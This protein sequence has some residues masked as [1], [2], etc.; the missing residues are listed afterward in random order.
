MTCRRFEQAVVFINSAVENHDPDASPIQ[1]EIILQQFTRLAG[2]GRQINVTERAHLTLRR[3]KIE[4]LIFDQRSQRLIEM[5]QIAFTE[6]DVIPRIGVA[7]F[8]RYNLAQQAQRARVVAGLDGFLSRVV[9]GRPS[10]RG[11]RWPGRTG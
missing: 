5:P 11:G 2:T 3:N 7:W 9:I 6:A 8:D 1:P 4:A 10:A